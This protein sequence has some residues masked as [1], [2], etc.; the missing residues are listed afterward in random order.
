MRMQT[1]RVWV[2]LEEKSQRHS[3]V[4]VMIV[5][6]GM[7]RMLKEKETEMENASRRNI[8]LEEHVKQSTMEKNLISI[9]REVEN[10]EL[11]SCIT[12]D[13]PHGVFNSLAEPTTI[14]DCRQIIT[15]IDI[16]GDGAVTLEE[17]YAHVSNDGAY[18][19][20]LNPIK[21]MDIA[22]HGRMGTTEFCA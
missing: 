4:L 13:E 6:K 9:A 10:L 1:E 2:V 22:L 16:N 20:A 19:S 14:D 12:A 5:E 7:M 8:E 3:R 17:F 15:C 18:G 11:S 21:Y